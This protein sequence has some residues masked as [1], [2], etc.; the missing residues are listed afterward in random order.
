MER[1]NLTE[2]LGQYVRARRLERGLS[3]RR[4]AAMA[5]VDFSWLAR[6]ER[7]DYASPD[8]RH[9]QAVAEALQVDTADLFLV[10]GY[11]IGGTLP[12]LAPYLRAKYDLPPEAVAQ[13]E[14]HFQLIN[15]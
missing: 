13:L 8:P 6:L 2:E 11:E 15:D 12:A 4:L 5:D 10:A 1:P 14:A 9:L 3:I 7:G